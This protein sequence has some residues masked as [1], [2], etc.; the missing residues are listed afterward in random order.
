VRRGQRLGANEEFQRVRRVG[1]SWSGPLLVLFVAEATRPDDPTLVGVTVGK[2]VGSA[3][4]RNRVRRRVRELL[5]LRYGELRSGRHIVLLVRPPAVTASPQALAEAVDSLL[6][7]SGAM[8]SE[9]AC[10]DSLSG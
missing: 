9:R 6:V 7:R 3:V 5:R 2:R 1:R 8:R 10:V 4:T